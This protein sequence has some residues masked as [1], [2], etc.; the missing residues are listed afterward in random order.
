VQ[1][2]SWKTPTNQSLQAYGVGA[3]LVF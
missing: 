3:I 2:G 1:F